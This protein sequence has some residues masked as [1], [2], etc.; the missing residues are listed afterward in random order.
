MSQPERQTAI[1]TVYNFMKDT[2]PNP[3]Y[4]REWLTSL[5]DDQLAHYAREV[6]QVS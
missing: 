4:Y 5:P 6:S 3:A 2:V 1:E